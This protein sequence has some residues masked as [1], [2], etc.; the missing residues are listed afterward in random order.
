MSAMQGDSQ[1]MPRVIHAEEY[2]DEPRQERIKSSRRVYREQVEFKRKSCDG[3]R[4]W[5]Y[6]RSAQSFVH[7]MKTMFEDAN[8]LRVYFCEFCNQWHTTSKVD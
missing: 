6:K 5:K 1:R 4:A 2:E 7:H 3:K 8:E